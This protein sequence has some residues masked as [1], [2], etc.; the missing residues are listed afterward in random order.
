MNKLTKILI[1]ELFVRKNTTK[2]KIKQV[3]AIIIRIVWI[4]TTT[5]VLGYFNFSRAIENYIW[6]AR[7]A[8]VEK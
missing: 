6:I 3:N 1:E 8:I 7:S 5:N 4:M 2:I